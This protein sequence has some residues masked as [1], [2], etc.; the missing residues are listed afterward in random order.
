MRPMVA[1]AL[2]QALEAQEDFLCTRLENLDSITERFVKFEKLA[3]TAYADALVYDFTHE[4]LKDQLIQLLSES[5]VSSSDD[6]KTLRTKK[7]SLSLRMV[8]SKVADLDAVGDSAAPAST[9]ELLRRCSQK[10]S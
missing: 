5:G 9:G 7:Y 2:S 8:P 4:R 3:S 1:T 10:F 6:T